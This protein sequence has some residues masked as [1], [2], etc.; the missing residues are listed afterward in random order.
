MKN[1]LLSF[2]LHVLIACCLTTAARSQTTAFSY[3]G[4]LTDGGGLANGVYDFVL[5]LA[6]APVAGSFTGQPYSTNGVPVTNGIFTIQPDFGPGA[7]NG[8]PRWLEIGVKTNGA[9]LPSLTMLSPRQPLLAAPLAQV[10]NTVLALPPGS[11]GTAELASRAVGANA[12]GLGA[13]GTAQIARGA[14]G[15]TELTNNAVGTV[16]LQDGAVT[17]PKLAD[18]SVTASKLAPGVVA[19]LGGGVPAGA[20]VAS[21]DP[22]AANLINGGYAAVPSLFSTVGGWRETPTKNAYPIFQPNNFASAWTG[23]EFVLYGLPLVNGVPAPLPTL[24][25]FNPSTGMWRQA[26]ANGMPGLLGGGPG[27]T[28]KLAVIGT[29][30]LVFDT[31]SPMAPTNTMGGRYDFVANTWQSLYNTGIFSSAPLP[32]NIPPTFETQVGAN[33]LSGFFSPL[34]NDHFI[35][36]LAANSWTRTSSANQPQI[37]VNPVLAA[38]LGTTQALVFGFSFANNTYTGGVYNVTA[39]TW[40]PVSTNGLPNLPIPGPTSSALSVWTGSELIWIANNPATSPTY[41]AYKP[42]TD[43][44]R[45]LNTN[46]VPPSQAPAATSLINAFWTGTEMGVAYASGGAAPAVS[47]SIKFNFYNPTTDTWRT[48]DAANSPQINSSPQ[49]PTV[50]V[51]WNATEVAVLAA[52]V[53]DPATPFNGPTKAYR[54]APPATLYFYQ[55]Q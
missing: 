46:G 37:D 54:F 45:S 14:V 47:L 21:F 7:I 20:L 42:S 16:H 5:A 27:T 26:V 2:S 32:G 13:V 36:N 28:P 31:L 40:R 41:F 10:A 15:A 34:T 25:F 22:N 24:A 35:Y 8:Q 19:G 50:A 18:G 38:G 29:E 53:V 49:G 23:S 30:V 12:I 33:I 39:D 1:K 4:R 52:N 6:D 55:K 17:T 44:W 11:V 9:P 48:V 51:V 3:Q 43:T